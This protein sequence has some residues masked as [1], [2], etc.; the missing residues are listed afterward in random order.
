MKAVCPDCGQVHDL[1]PLRNK[2]HPLNTSAP[3]K[4]KW[5]C[6]T[7]CEHV[8]EYYILPNGDTTFPRAEYLLHGL[9]YDYITTDFDTKEEAED[10]LKKQLEAKID[11]DGTLES[12]IT[13]PKR[14]EPYPADASG[15][16]LLERRSDD[17]MAFINFDRTIWAAGKTPSEAVGELW[18]VHSERIVARIVVMN[19]NVRKLGLA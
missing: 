11:K 14:Y 9:K 16:V 7:E 2:C 3:A 15:I 5:F 18:R 13:L 19:D 1:N 8:Q 17:Y 10:Y 6:C 12:N 4:Q